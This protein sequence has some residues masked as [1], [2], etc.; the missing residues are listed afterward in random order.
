MKG[1]EIRPGTKEKTHPESVMET[2]RKIS[3]KSPSLVSPHD[4]EHTLPSVLTHDNANIQH[5]YKTHQTVKKHTEANI[6]HTEV[7]A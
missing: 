5:T 4:N 6:R 1:N 7:S 2:K 3:C